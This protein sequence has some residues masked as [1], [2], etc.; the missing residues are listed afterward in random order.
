LGELDASLQL[1]GLGSIGAWRQR[2]RDQRIE[3]LGSA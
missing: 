3:R 1:P 2:A